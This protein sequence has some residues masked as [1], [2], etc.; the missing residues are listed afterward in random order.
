MVAHAQPAPSRP[1][2]T[3]ARPRRP[4]RPAHSPP[5]GAPASPPHARILVEDDAGGIPDVVLARLF[6]PFV[7]TKDAAHG[8]GLG[9]SI[10]HG[11]VR[12]MGGRIEA[13]N[14]A[15]G[16]LFTITLD[17]VPVPQPAPEPVNA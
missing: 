6:E 9:L 12:G 13:R 11:L 15:T 7:T 16:A 14:T 1:P 4:T 2:P 17:A 5:N 3:G 10:C 8:T